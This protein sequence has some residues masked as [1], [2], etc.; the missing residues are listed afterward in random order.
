MSGPQLPNGPALAG[1]GSAHKPARQRATKAQARCAEL[2]TG[3]CS[4]VLTREERGRVACILCTRPVA[5][6]ATG[7]DGAIG[8]GGSGKGAT[9]PSHEAPWRVLRICVMS[10][11]SR[12]GLCSTCV[13][14]ARVCSS[15]AAAREFRARSA[16]LHRNV[17]FGTHPLRISIID[18]GRMGLVVRTH[19]RWVPGIPRSGGGLQAPGGEGTTAKGG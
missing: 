13:G 6:R 15:G 10:C 1:G 9:G 8:A 5:H 12:R 4:T 16:W 19:C 7:T 3:L 2:G 17:R 18:T 14:A 11:I